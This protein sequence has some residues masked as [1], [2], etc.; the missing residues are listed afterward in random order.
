MI[1]NLGA[2]HQFTID[3]LNNSENW[4][5]VERAKIFYVPGF[6]IRTCSEAVFKLAHHAATMKKIF[7]LNLSAEYVC[8]NFG[9]HIMQLLPFV[10]F[11]FGNEQVDSRV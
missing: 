5:Y 10:D 4:M 6:F 1:T 9:D 3:Y 11:L 8:Q 2:A 7:T